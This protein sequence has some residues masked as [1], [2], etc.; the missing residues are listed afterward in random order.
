MLLCYSVLVLPFVLAGLILQ[1]VLID[2]GLSLLV[3]SSSSS[4]G[5]G[6]LQ[7]FLW[8]NLWL[9]LLLYWVML[10]TLSYLR[11]YQD[12]YDR[13]DGSRITF[14]EVWPVMVRNMAKVFFWSFLY[15]LLVVVGTLFLLIPGIFLGVALLFVP[16]GMVLKDQ[17][18]RGGKF[19]FTFIMGEWWS[20]FVFYILLVLVVKVVSS[21]LSLPS[22]IL[23]FTNA[24]TG[25]EAGSYWLM[26]TMLLASLGENLL[27]VVLFVGLGFKFFSIL[28][29]REHTELLRKIETL[30][31]RTP[32]S[33]DGNKL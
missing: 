22:F 10:E 12:K 26:F 4:S 19:S 32:E 5:G 9:L 24:F 27:K 21:L 7:S 3:E 29:S 28:E 30:G 2:E 11:V 31:D 23:I 14:K 15:L 6:Y 13:S 17:P 33:G 18:W 16:Y 8:T 25:E 20:T 1:A